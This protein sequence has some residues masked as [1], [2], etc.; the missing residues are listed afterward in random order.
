MNRWRQLINRKLPQIEHNILL[1]E[2]Y[3]KSDFDSCA[4]K[5][6]QVLEEVVDTIF[7]YENLDER[8]I[9]SI[10]WINYNDEDKLKDIRDLKNNKLSLSRKIS[11]LKYAKITDQNV[12]RRMHKIR[13]MGNKGSHNG[14][15]IGSKDAKDLCEEVYTLLEWFVYK[16]KS[17]I[18]AEKTNNFIPVN[19][20]KY[21]I[22][23]FSLFTISI[24]CLSMINVISKRKEEILTLSNKDKEI[25]QLKNELQN[26]SNTKDTQNSIEDTESLVADISTNDSGL[27]VNKG[28][29]TEYK[30]MHNNNEWYLYENN[31]LVKNSW[32]R[33]NNQ[34]YYL[35]SSGKALKNGWKK[36]NNVWYYFASKDQTDYF[37]KQYPECAMLYDTWITDG[38]DWYYV[39]EN[40]DMLTNKWVSEIID[41]KK[42]WYYVGED[43]KMLRGEHKIGNDI[44]Y[45]APTTNH[46]SYNSKVYRDGE[47]YEEEWLN[48]GN[49]K[50]KYFKKD[51][52]MAKN[53]KLMIDGKEYKFNNEGTY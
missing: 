37:G 8:K 27:I 6:R 12:D 25:E 31:V 44:F 49:G 2:K 16:Y 11:L 39:G 33:V 9:N 4:N 13:N 19:I 30:W 21:T 1:I 35:D 45:F 5:S 22:Y 32:K 34:Y 15:F 53:E 26:L 42:A 38:T 23:A 14:G 20:K 17:N 48:L 24:L 41:G 36:I 43:G 29:A 10:K 28:K 50:W 47:M 18:K 46:T 7:K 51:G 3:I 52:F 40:G